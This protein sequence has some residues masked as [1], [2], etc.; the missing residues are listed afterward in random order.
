VL[1]KPK[2][3]NILCHSLAHSFSSDDSTVF[4]LRSGIDF[5][6]QTSRVED[7]DKVNIMIVGTTDG[8]LHLSIYDSFVIGS[9]QSPVPVQSGTSCLIKHTF[10]PILPTQCLVMANKPVNP[11]NVHLVLMDLPFIS[12]SPINLSLLA[13]KLT[14]L[15]TLLRYLKQTQLHMQ[16]EWK[17]T[18]ELPSRFLRSVEGDLENM[19]SGPR[20]IVPALY[21]AVVTGHTH[22]PVREWLVDSLT[23]RVSS[24][25]KSCI[26]P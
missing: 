25:Y 7:Y 19:P 18:R 21:H 13:S 15:Q 26:D 5:L 14:T 3:L 4:T 6:F 10:H 17:N 11:E 1:G 12:S 24:L 9:L 23:E 2:V 20:G 16:V 8:K 22:E